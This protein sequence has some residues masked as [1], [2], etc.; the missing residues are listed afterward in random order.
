MCSSDL[1]LS[2]FL[3]VWM[4]VMFIAEI[5]E[6]IEKKFIELFSKNEGKIEEIDSSKCEIIDVYLEN[7]NVFDDVF[8]LMHTGLCRQ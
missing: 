8:P 6:S 4:L 2:A 3:L 7:G 5:P 1:G